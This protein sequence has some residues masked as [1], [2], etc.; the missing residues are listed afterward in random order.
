M[1]LESHAQLVSYV[2][3][4]FGDDAGVDTPALRSTRTGPRFYRERY[5][6]LTCLPRVE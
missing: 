6:E 2:L 4:T 1:R 3:G 5:L